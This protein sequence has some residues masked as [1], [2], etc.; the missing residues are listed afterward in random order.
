LEDEIKSFI[1]KSKVSKSQI[2]DQQLQNPDM[3]DGTLV[4]IKANEGLFQ[5]PFSSG[6]SGSLI[7]KQG[8]PSL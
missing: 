7:H 1:D 2:D 6:T 5:L 3:S 8:S 4:E